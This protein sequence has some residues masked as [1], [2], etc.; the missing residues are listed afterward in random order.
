MAE[1]GAERVRGGD[2]VLCGRVAELFGGV[3]SG[4]GGARG[5]GDDGSRRVPHGGGDRDQAVLEFGCGQRVALV[6]DPGQLCAQFVGVPRVAGVSLSNR[7]VAITWSTI[8]SGA[9]ASSARPIDVA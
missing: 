6:A 2:D 4:G 8:S 3:S 9:Q 7:V 1:V 5:D